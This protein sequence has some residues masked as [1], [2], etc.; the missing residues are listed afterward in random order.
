MEFFGREGYLAVPN[1]WDEREIAAMRA[2]LERLKTEGKLRNVA[3]D[4]DGKTTSTQK[5]NLQLCPISPHS[6]LFRALPFAPKVLEAVE[7]L[8]GGPVMLQLDQVF[9]K[10]GMHGAGTN[11]HQ[12]NDYFGIKQ[13]VQGT[14]MW[15]AIHDATAQNGT[16][17]V[18]P[19]AFHEAIPHARDPDSDHHVRMYPDENEAVTIEIEAGGILFFNYGTPHATGPNLT[20]HE[21]AAVAVHFLTCDAH[22][23]SKGAS[24]RKPILTGPDASDGQK[25]YGE[26]IAGTWKAE[27]EQV[28]Q[29]A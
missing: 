27:V 14:A 22:A 4:G 5:V 25:E 18:I 15:T 29:N 26:R 23:S 19:R 28:L 10:P 21:R 7:Q 9:L 20:Q 1:F 11:W 17:R 24:G 6:R 3:T 12:D 16:M 13:A 8:I 2:D